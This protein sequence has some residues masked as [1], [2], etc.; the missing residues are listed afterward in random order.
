VTIVALALFAVVGAGL[1]I[2]GRT[3]VFRP[4]V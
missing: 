4:L 1:A 3:E 2:G